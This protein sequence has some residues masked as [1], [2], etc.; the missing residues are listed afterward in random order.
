MCLSRPTRLTGKQIARTGYLVTD[1]LIP[2]ATFRSHAGENRHAH[3]NIIVDDHL[4][5]GIVETV[6]PARILGKRA[7]PCDR[8]GKEQGIKTGIVEALTK[9]AVSYTHLTLPTN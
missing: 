5:L 9:I 6:Q 3:I 2:D 7:F 8:H 4:A 1:S